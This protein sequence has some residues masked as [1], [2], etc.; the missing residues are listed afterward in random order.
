MVEEAGLANTIIFT[1]YRTDVA[2]VMTAMN[3]HLF[4]SEREGLPQ[5]LVQSAAIGLPVLAFEAEGVREMVYDGVN[6]YVFAHGDVD[7]MAAALEYLIH[8]PER[9]RTL[10]ENAPGLVDDR[11]QIET[12]QYKTAELYESLLR[13]KGL[14]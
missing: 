2:D 10:G 3:V 5:V 6:G 12:M 13:E 4:A 8:H 1:G 7:A 9:V 11:W 14:R